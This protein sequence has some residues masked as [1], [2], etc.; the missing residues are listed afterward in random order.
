MTTLEQFVREQ[1]RDGLLPWSAQRAAAE[2]FG[3]SCAGVEETILQLGIMPCRYQRNRQTISVEGQLRLFRSRVVVVGCGGLGGYVIEILA[4]L[5][6]GNL[7]VIDPDVFEEHNLNRQILSSLARIGQPKVEAAAAR[8]AEINPAVTLTPVRVCWRPEDGKK[9]LEG[10]DVVVD[11]LDS[12]PARLA[13]AATCSAM[14]TCFV[15]GAIAGW[16]GQ[17]AT[18]F[19]GDSILER[20][21]RSSAQEKGVEQ[22][23]GNPAFTPAIVASLQTAEVCK[24]ILGAGNLLHKR[25]VFVDLLEMTFQTLRL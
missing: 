5:G 1:A 22:R 13:L 9:I 16:Y 10:A 25:L 2:R 18:Q 23:L 3:I 11:A 8:V 17:A 19:P 7:V 6:I 14:G 15:H 12:K 4:R 20:I 24:I 21:Y